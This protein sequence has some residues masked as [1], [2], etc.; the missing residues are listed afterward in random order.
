MPIDGLMK[1][2]VDARA[3][4]ATLFALAHLDP[5]RTRETSRELGI[6]RG[7]AWRLTRI[8]RE[9]DPAIVASAMPA[10][11]GMGAFFDAC[12]KRGVAS[13][14][15]DAAAAAIERFEAA[16]AASSGDRKTL[17]LVL[18]NRGRSG[19]SE[20]ERARRSLF[21]GASGV[22]GVQAVARFVTV[23]AFP[24]PDDPSQIDAGHVTGFVGF[25]RLSAKPWPLSF[26]AVYHA[27]GA[28][29]PFTKEPLD[30]SGSG[31]GQL[32]LLKRFCSPQPPSI[33][34]REAAG[35]KRFELAA[36]PVGNE[37]LTTCVF[38]TRLR[39]LYERYPE[40]PNTAGFMVFMTTP[41][42]RVIFD[43]FVHRDLAVSAP[44][45]AMLLDRLS[46]PHT[47]IESEFARHSLPLAE[48]PAPLP[49]G[50]AGT[51]LPV[52]PW[53]MQLV[54]FV[55]ERLGQPITQFTGSRFEMAYPPISTVLRREFPLT[56]R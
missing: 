49:D 8:V 26:E 14:A 37:G 55:T 36:G 53:Y 39:R 9:S 42:E 51:A 40:T 12:R 30:P 33:E 15:I 45:R 48:A 22:W 19:A 17:A 32:Q 1:A 24:S 28:A 27:S 13:E 11:K 50:L 56:A 54:E 46:S 35:Y 20:G 44:P 5:T 43:M 3:A 41:V 16:L 21:E 18:A 25:R 23:F 4:I 47:M 6:N 34:V 29:A 31:E 7:L 2:F 52:I 38:G 10:G